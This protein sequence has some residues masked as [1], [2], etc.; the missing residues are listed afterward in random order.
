MGAMATVAA[1]MTATILRQRA[2]DRGDDGGD[3]GDDDNDC[4]TA[5]MA[6]ADGADDV[7]CFLLAG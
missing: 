6:A 2:C 1:M 3:G 4:G 5:A 7:V